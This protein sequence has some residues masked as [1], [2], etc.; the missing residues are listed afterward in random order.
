MTQLRD[1][2]RR[3][4]AAVFREW[5]SG[6]VSTLFVA[7]TGAGKT[8]IF[9]DIIARAQPRKAIVVAHREELIF[10]AIQRIEE[11]AGLDCDLEMAERMASVHEIFQAPVL[12]ATVQTLIS[13]K[14][15]ERFN[16]NDYGIL[17]IDEGHHGTADSYR[18]VINYFTRNPLLRV[19]GCTATPDR[20]DEEALGQ[21]FGSVA[22][23]YEILDA[24]HDGWLVPID[25]QMVRIQGLDFS[26]IRTTAGDLN[27]ADLAKVMEHERNLQGVCA[28]SLEI[29][30]DR[31][32]LVFTASVRHA[33]M[34]S[35]IFNRYRPGSAGWICGKTDK[36][37]RRKTMTDF[38]SGR[39]QILSNVGCLTEGV[40]VPAAEVVI[41][42]R[43][44]K[45]RSLYAQMAGR[46]LRPLPGIV[47]PLPTPDARREAIAAS[48]KP[49]A[50]IVDF[51]GN[52]GRHKLV[53]AADILGGNVS[54]KAIERAVE[55]AQES[56]QPV[57]VHRVLDEAEEEIRKEE[58]EQRKREA[59]RRARLTATVKYSAYKINPFDALD[60]SPVRDR[61]WDEGKV[62][63]DKARTLLMKQG[64][65]PEMLSYAQGKQILNTLFYRWNNKLAS[66]KQCAVLKKYGYSPAQMTR[67]EAS[68][69]LDQLARN[70][71]RRPIAA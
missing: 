57:R 54:E 43:P 27:N 31:R 56:G 5:E 30:G 38:A 55:E 26:S 66:L 28:A 9:T 21:I 40:D 11:Q 60:I 13:G 34:A 47:D 8:T 33:E 45:S 64:V 17:V 68:K 12:V 25:Q 24:I 3:A 37:E 49:S 29:I 69:T 15:M 14:R 36:E 23:V 58:E 18:R 65:N 62:L 67:E 44:T 41:M 39:I 32:A 50:L 70:K 46:A 35:E 22:D 71:W 20:A 10:Q 48:H 59:A 7:P 51:V 1:Y 63:S 52:A 2:Q 61:G 6:V 16:P 53:T 42:A 19:V 4:V